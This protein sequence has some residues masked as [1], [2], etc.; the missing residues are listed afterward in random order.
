MIIKKG[1]SCDVLFYDGISTTNKTT[2]RGR[3]VQGGNNIFYLFYF[4]QASYWGLKCERF[5]IVLLFTWA[6][7]SLCSR[8]L[9]KI[10]IF[11]CH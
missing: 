6:F 8:V 11:E 4:V 2:S 5:P 10:V 1:G 7:S 3:I 9:T